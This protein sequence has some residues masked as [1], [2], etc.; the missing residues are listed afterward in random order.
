MSLEKRVE[1]IENAVSPGQW[2]TLCV[3]SSPDKKEFDRRCEQVRLKALESGTLKPEDKI[4]F[5]S[6]DGVEHIAD[7]LFR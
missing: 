7:R 6:K 1:A 2:V 5:V 3:P 4:I